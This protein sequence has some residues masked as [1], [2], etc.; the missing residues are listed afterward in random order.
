VSVFRFSHTPIETRTLS[1]ELA[2]PACGG[3]A[4]FEGWVRDHNDGEHVRHLEYEA[5]EVLAVRE[6]ERIVAEAIAR[7]TGREPFATLDGVRMSKKKMFFT[8]S[9]AV[10]ELGYAPR[11]ARE[12]IADAVASIKS[13]TAHAMR[14]GIVDVSDDGRGLVYRVT[15]GTRWASES[16]DARQPSLLSTAPSAFCG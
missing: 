7:V 3:Y 9:R 6:G 16:V 8:T 2:D 15:A 13:Q 5:F 11:P 4:A 14:E 10:A 1:A 12:A